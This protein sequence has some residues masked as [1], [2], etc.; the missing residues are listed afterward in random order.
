MNGKLQ[1]N[2]KIFNK[3]K[4]H[5]ISDNDLGTETQF[6]SSLNVVVCNSF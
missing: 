2:F 3:A 4:Y 1:L 5:I 6:K